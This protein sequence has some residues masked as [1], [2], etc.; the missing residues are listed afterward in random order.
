MKASTSERKVANGSQSQRNGLCLDSFTNGTCFFRNPATF[1]SLKRIV[2]PDIVQGR[3]KEPARI[4]IVGCGTGEEAYSFAISFLEFWNKKKKRGPAFQL[5]AT[6]FDTGHLA[7]ARRGFYARNQL[8]GV[9]RERRERFFVEVD[10]GYLVSKELREAVVFARQNPLSDPPFSR[11]D[12]ISCR[13]HSVSN[14]GDLQK[15]IEIFHYALNPK[16]Y[17]LLDGFNLIGPL[18]D[19]FEFVD[20]RHRILSKKSRALDSQAPRSRGVPSLKAESSGPNMGSEQSA[21]RE[22]DR[23]IA[24]SYAPPGV[25]INAELQIIQFRGGTSPFLETPT[26][27]A[28][29]DLL[30]MARQGLAL[31]LR[32][33]IERARKEG[34]T[35]RTGK[36]PFIK[37]GRWRGVKVDVIPM[38]N[39]TE[40]SFLILFEDPEKARI[41]PSST[42]PHEK[43]EPSAGLTSSQLSIRAADLERELAETR[44]YLRVIQE[45]HDVANEELQAANE[46]VQS[47]NEELQS[48]NEELQTSKEELQSANEELISANEELEQRVAER[49]KELD[50]ALKRL[51]KL[52]QELVRF[53]ENERLSIMTELHEEILQ[54]L[55]ALKMLLGRAGTASG[56]E[57]NVWDRSALLVSKIQARVETLSS[58]LRPN[59]PEFLTLR[60][61]LEDHFRTLKEEA[62]L[63]VHFECQGLNENGF[64]PE[65]RHALFRI[66]RDALTNVVQHAH[67]RK[68]KVLLSQTNGE[69]LLEI[70]D[71]GAGFPADTPRANS[72]H[73]ISG[74]E[75]RVLLLGGRFFLTSRPGEG[76]RVTVTLPCSVPSRSQQESTPLCSDVTSS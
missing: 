23:I 9:S 45:Q 65:I 33:A 26:G 19:S 43:S 51:Q 55:I 22:A 63:K 67:V 18:T 52:A 20:K 36:I 13:N 40:R 75:E 53:Q 21:L 74:I 64:G 48:F 31:P 37:D 12:L 61:A 66:T 42:G 29:F 4:W 27:K 5:Y 72:S 2:F 30:R 76:T 8:Q 15:I 11:L 7:T 59:I 56:D 41:T 49:T 73:G 57:K 68:A 32:K 50:L 25:V 16:G 17:L 38:N 58:S 24:N 34:K 6:D 44:D 1:E 10:G 62:R 3:W 14:Q 54:L 69:V 46:E 47:S 28:S 71:R 39:L 60:T 35:V 70:S